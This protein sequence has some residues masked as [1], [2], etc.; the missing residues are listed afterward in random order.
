M[1][2][3][4]LGCGVGMVTSLLAEMVGP[5]GKVVGLDFSGAQIAQARELLSPTSSN[6]TFVEA[7]A[8]STG[9]PRES[10][11]LS[12]AFLL[13]HLTEPMQAT[14]PTRCAIF[15]SR[16]AFSYVKMAI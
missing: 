2:V 3:A 11:D 14:P 5:S 12:I 10:F 13:I 4:D 16:K 15:S 9:L 1:K 8:T 6:V 7:S